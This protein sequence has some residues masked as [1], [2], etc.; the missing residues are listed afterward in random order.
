M[1]SRALVA[2]TA[3]CAFSYRGPD[4]D[5]VKVNTGGKPFIRLKTNHC[6]S[7]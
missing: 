3:I 5:K 7:S 4:P 1:N 2:D 6:A